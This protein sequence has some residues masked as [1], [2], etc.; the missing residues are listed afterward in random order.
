MK[1]SMMDLHNHLFEQLER[2]ND[3]ELIGDELI[4]EIK[5]GGAMVNIAQVLIE[6]A[7]LIL[8]AK[9][10]E[11]NGKLILPEILED[12]NEKKYK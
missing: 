1:N 5:R 12:K 10:F 6:N 11:I 3:D 4:D 2:L 8:K 7:S 9:D